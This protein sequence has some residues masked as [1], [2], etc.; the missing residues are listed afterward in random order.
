[1]LSVPAALFGQV[2]QKEETVQARIRVVLR[3]PFFG[4]VLFG[5]DIIFVSQR[6][7]FWEREFGIFG[8][9]REFDG[10]FFENWHGRKRIIGVLGDAAGRPKDQGQDCQKPQHLE[11][12]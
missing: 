7:V 9:I 11:L 12:R 10:W 2:E 3:E 4:Q 6:L 5:G 8:N 1:M